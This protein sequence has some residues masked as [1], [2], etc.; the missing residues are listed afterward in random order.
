M[1]NTGS[2]AVAVEI[3]RLTGFRRLASMLFVT[4]LAVGLLASGCAEPAGSA[5][6]PN[7]TGNPNTLS[8]ISS[9]LQLQVDLRKAQLANPTAERLSQ[10]ESQGMDVAD[11]GTHKIYIHLNQQLTSE[12]VSELQSMG[13]RVFPDSWIP[14]VG[15]QPTGFILAE[16][17]VNRLDELAGKNYVVRLDTAERKLE[18]QGAPSKE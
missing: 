1:K 13:I 11:I 18:P 9:T 2:R 16:V 3:L 4:F 7:G 10:M 15:V 17:P 12:Q 5:S 14:P 8:K 6:T